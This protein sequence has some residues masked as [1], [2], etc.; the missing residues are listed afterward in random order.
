MSAEWE[1]RKFIAGSLINYWASFSGSVTHSTS[2][3][4]LPPITCLDDELSEKA[5]LV[6]AEVTCLVPALTEDVLFDRQP[7]T[8]PLWGFEVSLQCGRWIFL[9]AAPSCRL[10]Q[11]PYVLSDDR[12]T[13]KATIWLL[14]TFNCLSIYIVFLSHLCIC[15]S[16]HLSYSNI[17]ILNAP[18]R[19]Q[20]LYSSSPSFIFSHP[21]RLK[22][23]SNKSYYTRKGQPGLWWCWKQLYLTNLNPTHPKPLQL[24]LRQLLT[25]QWNG[26]NKWT[27][28][29]VILHHPASTAA[30]IKTHVCL[31]AAGDQTGRKKP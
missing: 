15:Q 20:P 29:P 10:H 26:A 12:N 9:E 5:N 21:L 16:I 1:R 7:P 4:N 11:Q 18:R 27:T 13:S 2:S 30:L 25:A 24:M 28:Q 22:N 19:L 31:A 17:G 8:F 14:D 3:I 23:M 6:W